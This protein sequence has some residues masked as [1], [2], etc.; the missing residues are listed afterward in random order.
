MADQ[1]PIPA[2]VRKEAASLRSQI[3]D[4][5]HRYYVL[6]DPR[7]SDEAYDALMKRLQELEHTFPALKTADSPTQRVGGSP[8]KE[9]PHVTHDV[10]ML[11]LANSYNEKDME[12][13]HG[14]VLTTLDSDSVEYVCELKYDGVA[15]SL[16][17]ENGIL[18]R[19]ATRGDGVT[20]DDIT[21]NIR[22]IRAIPLR[23][24]TNAKPPARCEIRGE[25]YM[26]RE[27]FDNMNRERGEQGLKTF[28]NPRNSAAGTLKLQDPGEVA[29]RPL[30]FVAHGLTSVMPGKKSHQKNLAWLASVGFGTSQHT[31][32]SS[33]PDVLAFW[34]KWEEGRD[35]L[36]FDI[37]GIVVKV[38]DLA[39]Q[40]KLGAIAKSPRW[41]MALKFA[42]RKA[43][44]RLQGILFQVGRIGTVTPVADL[45]PV[46]V[47]GS[48][49]S[50]ATLHNEDYISSLDIRI[51][52][53]VMV[54]KGG[55]VIPKVSA[56]VVSKR[57]RGT[58]PF[59]FTRT[60]PSC[61]TRLHRPPG[62]A[63]HYCENVQCPAQVRERIRHFGSR[64][65]MDIEGLGEAVVDMLVAGEFVHD[66]ADLYTLGNH[67]DRLA[68]LEGWGPK[69]VDNLLEGI[70]QSKK[71][72]FEKVLFSVG[73]RHVGESVAQ[74]IARA[75]GS[76]DVLLGMSQEDLEN[77]PGIGP[78]IAESV[79]HV[80][81]DP[82]TRPVLK[83]LKEAGLRMKIEGVSGKGN[84]PLSGKTIVLTGTL[85]SL[86]RT[87][88]KKRIEQLGGKVT[89]SVSS[90]TDY[91]IAGEDAGSKL[92]KAR[93]LG[94]T[95][96]DESGFN[97][98]LN[99]QP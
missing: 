72:I 6:A 68:E 10:P 87:D 34:Q 30:Q 80:L 57:P 71:K 15:V 31:I 96:L 74:V 25:V 24:R 53:I 76:M 23:L 97:T 88:A 98:L 28:V 82:K 33:Q 55:D 67:K 51:G 85:A 18:T 19:G 42:S 22:T 21:Q 47:G 4:H 94:V 90:K 32:A 79:F 91:V 39:Q 37:D 12:D 61:K 38:N 20:G 89:G 9:F 29:Q 46:F 84:L 52:D 17:Y 86:S 95:I 11:S 59:V 70:D 83:R 36:P 56:A 58:K 93:D 8:L 16:V 41:A 1:A 62:E 60:C 81:R 26:R 40:E 7:I 69:S 65:A 64:T 66:V 99:Q 63:N 54:E 48:T 35:D 45:E 50:R 73:I 75:V 2:A 43:E 92:Q 13:F 3:T 5:D 14:R 44:T 77:I 27:D 49:V 78:K